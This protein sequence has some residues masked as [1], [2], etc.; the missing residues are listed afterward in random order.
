MHAQYDWSKLE[1]SKRSILAAPEQNIM[2]TDS[3]SRSFFLEGIPLNSFREYAF[4]RSYTSHPGI[5][6]NVGKIEGIFPYDAGTKVL[7]IEMDRHMLI[8]HEKLRSRSLKL[9][10]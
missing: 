9:N 10:L 5:S 3:K 6:A 4:K 2:V 1:K 8:I 7:T